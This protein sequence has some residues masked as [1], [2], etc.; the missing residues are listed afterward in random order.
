MN[1]AFCLNRKIVRYLP[2][3]FASIRANHTEASI[4]CYVVHSDL[5]EEDKDMLIA[6]AKKFKLT[7]HIL[8]VDYSLF[9][10]IATPKGHA[11]NLHQL[12]IETCFR[13]I[14]PDV[15]PQTMERVLY[16]DVDIVID[17]DLYGLYNMDFKDKAL[18][19]TYDLQG[20]DLLSPAPPPINLPPETGRYFN[21]GV[22]L[23][24]LVYL[25]KNL[26]FAKYVQASKSIDSNLF[27]QAILNYLFWD[28]ALYVSAL[29]YN[30]GHRFDR[31]GLLLG[32]AK[33]A[34]IHYASLNKPW[35]FWCEDDLFADS[36]YGSLL[37][38]HVNRINGIWWKYA[39]MCP[40]LFDE[41]YLRMRD[42]RAILLNNLASSAYVAKRAEKYLGVYEKLYQIGT[43]ERL[44]KHL[45]QYDGVGIYG[46]GSLGAGFTKRLKAS[47][48]SV[49]VVID[50]KYTEP[51]SEDGTLFTSSLQDAAG[52]D[53]VIITALMDADT[54]SSELAEHTPA[55]TIALDALLEG[56]LL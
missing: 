42:I 17:E 19:V 23:L 47:G 50:K 14:L 37:T 54:I 4:T 44:D 34:I 10:K 28:N 1:I 15:L 18:V 38:P 53:I 30:Y 20:Y 31:D 12:P 24:N 43:I 13:F 52:V 29:K 5:H 46:Y 21:A 51:L 41:L 48:V 3:T 6:F 9:E 35:D 49:K 7:L 36:V 56:E 27:S 45:K 39:K 25:R 55:K 26:S 2:V 11:T 32:D 16:L 40:Q 33:P 22:M 8:H